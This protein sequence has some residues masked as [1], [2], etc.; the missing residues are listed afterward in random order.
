MSASACTPGLLAAAL[1]P[2]LMPDGLHVRR[3]RAQIRF[4]EAR[5]AETCEAIS[6]RRSLRI[7][8]RVF[9]SAVHCCKRCFG[10]SAP[11]ERERERERVLFYFRAW[12][13]PLLPKPGRDLRTAKQVVQQ[14]TI[15][16]RIRT[17]GSRRPWAAHPMGKGVPEPNW[18]RKRMRSSGRLPKEDLSRR[19]ARETVA[20]NVGVR[21][22]RA[23]R[24]PAQTRER[25]GR[26]AFESGG[27]VAHSVQAGQHSRQR[28]R[29]HPWRAP[30]RSAAPA[31]TCSG[32]AEGGLAVGLAGSISGKARRRPC[33][34]L[35]RRPGG[36]LGGQASGRPGQSG[37]RATRQAI[38]Q[39]RGQAGGRLGAQSG[40][41]AARRR[42]AGRA[43]RQ[44]AGQAGGWTARRPSDVGELPHMRAM[45]WELWFRRLSASLFDHGISL[46][47]RY[48]VRRYGMLIV[49]AGR[50][51]QERDPA[52]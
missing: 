49:F 41:R 39:A 8:R 15:V 13:D 47:V 21:P 48:P 22:G 46:G 19:R 37:R 36:R 44:A 1:G 12:S 33:G 30:H 6:A 34:R 14:W 50:R 32:R 20:H 26:L 11:C 23:R 29:W 25:S 42:R 45:R 31:P 3:A 9:A 4:R 35:G 52:S 16:E 27:F 40:T 28:T 17:S 24:Q 38:R 2:R 10:A 18:F 51:R 7:R 43:A 5:A